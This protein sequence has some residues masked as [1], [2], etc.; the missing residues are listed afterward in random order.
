MVECRVHSQWLISMVECRCKM[1][2]QWL[3]SQWLSV[4]IVE[5]RCRVHS[6]LLISM[7]ECRV[8]DDARQMPLKT[9]IIRK[10]VI[11]VASSFQTPRDIGTNVLTMFREDWTTNEVI[12]KA[13]HEHRMIW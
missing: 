3:S 6:Q 8:H 13:Y 2:Y 1:H 9:Q 10:M 4:S 7:V 11:N 5:C 12:T